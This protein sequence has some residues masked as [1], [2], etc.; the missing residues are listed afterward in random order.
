MTPELP[1]NPTDE[2]VRAC[3]ELAK[4]SL[5][6]DFRASV[7]RLAEDHASSSKAASTVFESSRSKPCLTRLDGRPAIMSYEVTSLP[8]SRR[9][10]GSSPRIPISVLVS[11]KAPIPVARLA[12]IAGRATGRAA[13][14]SLSPGGL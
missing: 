14:E 10:A 2:Q 11:S 13:R 3:I 7:R 12:V 1:D 8:L 5:D 9:T 6:P 4:L